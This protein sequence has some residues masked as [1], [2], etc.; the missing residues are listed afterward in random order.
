MNNAVH[1][2][3]QT[4]FAEQIRHLLTVN[5]G[6]MLLSQLGEMYF[7]EFGIRFTTEILHSKILSLASHVAR[8]TG[9]KWLIWE[10][11]NFKIPPRNVNSSKLHK[12]ITTEMCKCPMEGPETTTHSML[13]YLD[14][15]V[16]NMEPKLQQTLEGK[17]KY[18]IPRNEQRDTSN[19][20]KV[21]QKELSRN[22]VHSDRPQID[23]QSGWDSSQVEKEANELEEND[24]GTFNAEEGS[25]CLEK[26]CT[27]HASV[28][29]STSVQLSHKS[30]YQV[31]R[32][33]FESAPE[34]W[35]EVT[36]GHDKD[37][38]TSPDIEWC[39]SQVFLEGDNLITGNNDL[40]RNVKRMDNS[41]AISDHQLS[42]EFNCHLT[43][44]AKEDKVEV[45][46]KSES[47]SF[48]KSGQPMPLISKTAPCIGTNKRKEPSPDF[49]NG[50]P[51]KRNNLAIRFPNSD[52]DYRKAQ[53]SAPD[54][55]HLPQP[56][57]DVALLEESSPTKV[58]A[59]RLQGQCR[60]P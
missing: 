55:S 49:I 20:A 50:Q 30:S 21:N 41:L 22:V 19:N 58:E 36:S 8:I 3:D 34:I 60:A 40:K 11:P 12:V 1:L 47:K 15:Q 38:S 56:E 51:R 9:N 39:P 6:K 59:S 37:G 23:F 46:I 17:V 29:T 10:T 53:C 48:E 24:E 14:G 52:V 32:D 5:S 26:N 35:E 4:K 25:N 18:S 45:S 28:T 2:S 31:T 57:D 13:P 54:V 43:S 44:A 33:Q 7:K 42:V 27:G 16:P